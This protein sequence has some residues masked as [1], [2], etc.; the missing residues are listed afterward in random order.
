MTSRVLSHKK[1]DQ[2]ATLYRNDRLSQLQNI[3]QAKAKEKKKKTVAASDSWKYKRCV[4]ET[5]CSQLLKHPRLLLYL[6][7]LQ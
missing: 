6:L 3:L 5:R 2:F 4:Q 7:Y 1:G